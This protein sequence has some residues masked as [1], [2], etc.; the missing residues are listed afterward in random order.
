MKCK[1]SKTEETFEAL[2]ET[3]TSL[4]NE[5]KLLALLEVSAEARAAEA[6]AL[7]EHH[8]QTLATRTERFD[9]FKDKKADEMKTIRHKAKAKVSR[10]TAEHSTVVAMMQLA[11]QKSHA[12]DTKQLEVR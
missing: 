10:M 12:K 2:N 5:N 9:N 11:S 8:G 3:V 7:A 6:R 4:E 1:L